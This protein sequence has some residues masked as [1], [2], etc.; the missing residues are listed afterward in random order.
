MPFEYRTICKLDNFLPFEYQTSPVFRWLLYLEVA[1]YFFFFYS[2]NASAVVNQSL[3]ERLSR[4]ASVRETGNGSRKAASVGANVFD[5]LAKGAPAS[6][7]A[8]GTRRG[9]GALETLTSPRAVSAVR[10]PLTD[11]KDNRRTNG[12][13]PKR[14]ALTKIRDLVRYSCKHVWYL[15]GQPQFPFW[16]VN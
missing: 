10:S 16:M 13:L 1:H 12:D 7:G 9:S 5:R 8:S 3:I 2:P 4:S 15:N 6:L 11:E 14:G